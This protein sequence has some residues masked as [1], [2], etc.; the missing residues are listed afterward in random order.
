[1]ASTLRVRARGTALVC[2]IEALDA[3]VKRF[4]GRKIV[5]IRPANPAVKDDPGEWG[6]APT[7]EAVTV[8]ARAEYVR[9]VKEGSL[10]AADAETAALCGVPFEQHYGDEAPAVDVAKED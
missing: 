7:G 2:D 6:F 3:G 8:P 5:C 4:I 10:E 1:M 9:D